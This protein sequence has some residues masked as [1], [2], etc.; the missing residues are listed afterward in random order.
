[1]LSD[2]LASPL[3]T[4]YKTSWKKKKW[5]NFSFPSDGPTLN[6]SSSNECRQKAESE[7]QKICPN[8]ASSVMVLM[9]SRVSTSAQFD[10]PARGHE[11]ASSATLGHLGHELLRWTNLP[12]SYPQQRRGQMNAALGFY[13]NTQPHISINALHFYRW[14]YIDVCLFFFFE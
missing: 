11:A 2:L 8:R 13:Y 7:Q 6:H 1:M 5:P 14:T 9:R 10:P 4:N 12:K 3:T